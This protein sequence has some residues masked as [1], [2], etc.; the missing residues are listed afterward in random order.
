MSNRP[1]GCWVT[2]G[3]ASQAVSIPDAAFSIRPSSDPFESDSFS[4]VR[5]P[6]RSVFAVPPRL[7][8]RS[9]TSCSGSFPHRGVTEGVHSHGSFPSPATFR[10]QVFSTS[11][12]FPPPSASRACCI[13]QPRPGFIR[14]GV[15]PDPQPSLARRQAV[16][17]CRCRSRPHRLAGCHTRAPRLRG[18]APWTDAFRRVGV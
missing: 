9:G 2:R 13:P 3:V 18:F 4:R 10:P 14:S 6:L 12:R 1:A 5:C 17:P 8:F 16:P 15:S 11:R 7:S